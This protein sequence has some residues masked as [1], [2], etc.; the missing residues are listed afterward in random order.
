M[1]GRPPRDR[2]VLGTR[3]SELALHQ[4]RRVADRLRDAWPELAVETAGV[5]TEGDRVLDRPLPE[6]GGKGLFTAELEEALHAGE[7]DAAVHSLKDLPTDM[8]P[9]F[10]VLGVPERADPRDVLLGPDGP[11]APEELAE[12]AV[13]GT[14]SLRRRAQ[15]LRLRP[16]CEVRDVRGNVGTRVEKMRAGDYDAV[17]LAAAGLIRLELLE[18][19][20]GPL[21]EPPAW[22]PA[23]G[24][25]AIGVEGRA[26]DDATRA[27][28]AAIESEAVRA[29][30]TA[31]RAL[32]ATLEAGCSVP[33]GGLARAGDGV[34]R[35]DAVVLSE[36]GEREL[37]A[38]GEGPFASVEALGRRLGREL[39]ERGAAELLSG[40]T[41][42]EA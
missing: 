28:L 4:T 10:A 15:L 16:D 14:S 5:T 26:D 13:V 25:G 7:V 19:G 1:G 36:D 32:L 23:P 24:Q 40:G 17:L 18:P 11:L 37:R 20:A 22:L 41:G 35:L 33:V 2:L 3:T 31:E 21:L 6:L 30:A 12:G 42:A 39:L 9:A 27:L 8:D 34:V 29:E 38:S